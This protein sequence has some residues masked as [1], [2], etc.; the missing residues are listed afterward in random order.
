MLSPNNFAGANASW[1]DEVQQE[2]IDFDK[3]IAISRRQ[4]RVVAAAAVVFF[5]LGLVYVLTAVPQYT[6][7]TDILIDSGNS[8]IA[9]Q[10]SSLSSDGLTDDDAAVLSQ[11]ELMKSD[12]VAA[13]VIDKLH[14]L[15]N[16][17]FMTPPLSPLHLLR[18]LMDFR[19]WFAD[20]DTV[21]TESDEKDI[22]AALLAQNMV[23]ERLGRTYVLSISYTSTSPEL[24]ANISSAI[25]D[26]YL[27][28]KLNSSMTRPAEPA[29]G[30]SSAS[31]SCD[32][33]LSLLIWMY[34]NSARTTAS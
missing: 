31:R 3:V 29:T 6:A 4:W 10:L 33:R 5:A 26:A 32:R 20:E 21:E 16:Q 28:D 2:F 27:L 11:I 14:L 19:A 23:V 22:A 17:A 12:S 9:N 24:S 18:R 8:Q 15:Q 30:C 7:T 13:S 1:D 34:R 25:A